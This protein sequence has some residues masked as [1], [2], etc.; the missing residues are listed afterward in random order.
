MKEWK[1]EICGYIHG[2]QNPPKECP[3]CKAKKENF[4]EVKQEAKQWRCMV[5]GY[6]HEGAVPPESCPLCKATKEKFE[7][8][9][10]TA[11]EAAAKP[12]EPPVAQPAA[13]EEAA[14]PV[15]AKL[16]S[17][18]PVVAASPAKPAT[19]KRWRCLVCGHVHEGEAPPAHCPLCK[20][21]A[22]QFAELDA[23]GNPIKKGGATTTTAPMGK[24]PGILA[25]I[26]M[27]LHVHPI[28]AHF[29]NGI[30]PMVVV[31]MIGSIFLEYDIFVGH[32]TFFSLLFVLVTMPFV[33][34]SGFLEWKGR[35]QGART[36]L[37]AIKIF[38]GFLAL[39]CL[40]ALVL[41]HILVPDVMSSPF[42]L[43]YFIIAV[44]MLMAVAIAGHLGG[45]LVFKSRGR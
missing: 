41:W 21:P 44:I 22:S 32:S 38:C 19:S 33:L 15:E 20:A 37:F 24:K 6:I 14:N 4:S 26:L 12:A 34:A 2:G 10:G 17:A 16:E 39:A 11:S 25:R 35:Y 30:L 28:L 43:F 8:L 27:G 42:R 36:V 5:C 45:H 13:K 23:K 1:C 31:F 9:P 7:V 40:A 29:P 18:A 3:I